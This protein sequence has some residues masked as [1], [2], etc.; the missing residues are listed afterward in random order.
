MQLAQPLEV[1]VERVE[2]AAA[3]VQPRALAV[4]RRE[5][6]VPRGAEGLVPVVPVVPVVLHLRRIPGS[7]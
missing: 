4:P 2:L 1:P 5:P 6:P 3:E 7:W